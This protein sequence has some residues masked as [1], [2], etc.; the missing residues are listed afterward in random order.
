M[1]DAGGPLSAPAAGG[2]KSRLAPRLLLA[3]LLGAFCVLGFAPFDAWFAVWPAPTFALGGL[4]LLW[5]AATPRAAAL[6]GLA[7]GAGCFLIGVSWVYVSLSQFGG[8]APPAAAAA[9]LAFCL[10]LALFPA[11]AGYAFRRIASAD[12]SRPIADALLFAGVWTLTEWLRGTLFTGF[13]WLAI[14]YSQ[15]PPSP[16]AGW[17]SVLGV[18]GLGF[19]VALIAALL[20]TGWRKPATWTVVAALLGAGGLL[21]AM[22]WTQPAGAPITVSLLQGNVPQSLKWD[23]EH[24]P[25]SVNTYVQLAK[26]HPAALTVLPETA[27]PLFFDEVPRDVLRGVTTHGDALIGVAVGTTDG[28]YT[29]GAVA[30]TREL[31][32]SAYAKRHLVPF[33]EYPPPGFAWFFRF[34][35]IPMSE[36]TAGPPRQE[37]LAV[38]GQRIAPNICYEDLFG[39]ELLAAVPTA[40]LL[41]NLSNTAWFG[42]SLA[43]PQHLQ[44]ARLRAIETGRVMLRATN[45][46]MTAMVNPDGAIAAALPPFTTAALVVQAQG[47]NGLTPYAR[48]GNALA[49]LIAFGACLAALR[50]RGS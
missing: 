43:Q 7:W 2:A 31:A 20:A 49:L 24:L 38:G 36:F 39:E 10:Y 35:H 15:S 19:I 9:T 34:A 23:P 14:G 45:T 11:L 32:A 1:A 16:L 4:Y 8:M 25:R 37:A 18:Y 21:R 46:G 26:A 12:F 3:G 28:G 47:R 48:W 22:D 5:R 33:G 50:R 17:A 30:L 40:T 27:L 29:N 41:V 42:D 6:L 13:P 44:I